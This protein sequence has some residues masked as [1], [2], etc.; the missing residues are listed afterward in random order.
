VK[1]FQGF[2]NERK[3]FP[4][5]WCSKVTVISSVGHCC[6]IFDC[7][8]AGGGVTGVAMGMIREYT[9]TRMGGSSG[10]DMV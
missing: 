5:S 1:D 3:L 4:W 2:F 6:S 9:N 10:A 7:D 8:Y